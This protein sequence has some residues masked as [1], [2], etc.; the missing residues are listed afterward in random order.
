[1]QLVALPDLVRWRFPDH[2]VERY[3]G[4]ADH[5]FGRLWWR[6]FVLGADLI[7]G[8][9]SEPLTEDELVALFRRRDLVANPAVA[10]VLSAAVL[11][12]AVAGPPRLALVKHV[13]LALLRLTPMIEIDAL[14]SDDLE[15]LV[16]RLIESRHPVG[17]RSGTHP[18][19]GRH[20]RSLLGAGL[21]LLVLLA[22]SFGLA[23]SFA[24]SAERD[25]GPS[26]ARIVESHADHAV[27]PPASAI[28][29]AARERDVARVLRVLPFVAFLLA[30]AFA[31]ASLTSSSS[32]RPGGR[33]VG[34]PLLL[35]SGVSRR[36]PP[37]VG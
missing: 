13:T 10:Q 35:A 32:R 12:S 15:R 6:A 24:A 29:T 18:A 11:R 9:G 7:D 3:V 25:A 21:M 22:T 19:M 1:M 14:A 34:S 17:S 5:T 37:L 20:R 36:G 27:M 31:A 30:L 8:L 16:G 26:T 23:A 4:V 2:G 28:G 33:W